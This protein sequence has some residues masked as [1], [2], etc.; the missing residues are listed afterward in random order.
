MANI[1]L[2][3]GVP[4]TPRRSTRRMRIMTTKNQMLMK[5]SGLDFSAKKKMLQLSWLTT[6]SLDTKQYEFPKAR[7]L[8]RVAK[9]LLRFAHII[10]LRAPN[11]QAKAYAESMGKRNHS[12]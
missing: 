9:Q 1:R 6:T 10:V 5:M 11:P 12:L 4:R 2:K 7:L 3:R 8:M